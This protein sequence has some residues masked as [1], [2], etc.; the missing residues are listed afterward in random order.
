[1]WGRRRL[2]VLAR[3]LPL[4]V[5]D[6]AALRQAAE[7][8]GEIDDMIYLAPN[9]GPLHV[10][11]ADDS[12]PLL[13]E[14]DHSGVRDNASLRLDLEP[15]LYLAAITG[16]RPGVLH[17]NRTFLLQDDDGQ[18]LEAFSI[19]AGLDYPGIGPEHSWLH[20]IGRAKYVAITDKE[21]LEAF[22]MLTE[23]E[24]IIPALESAHAV[25]HAMAAAR[26]LEKDR[27]IIVN[28]SGRG[29][30]DIHTIAQLDGIEI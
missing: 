6:S 14:D 16:G 9:S 4:A 5:P 17:G 15:G 25:A 8:V 20:D 23:L 22:Q 10:V 26:E 29:D 30:K 7:D 19:S 18:I 27:T 28:L 2:A 21:A 13:A 12:R 11:A 1:M 3:V 24:G